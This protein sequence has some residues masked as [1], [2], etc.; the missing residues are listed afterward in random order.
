MICLRKSVAINL[1][2]IMRDSNVWHDPDTFMPERFLAAKGEDEEGDD[3]SGVMRKS[4]SFRFVS[5]VAEEEAILDH[6]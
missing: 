5:L 3:E 4:Q 6:C 1:D 2:S